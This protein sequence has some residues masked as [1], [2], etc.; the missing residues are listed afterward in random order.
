MLVALLALV[1][2]STGSAV[3][4]SLITSKQIKDGTIQTKDISKKAQKALRGKTGPQGPQGMHGPKGDT[5]ATGAQGPKG[6]TGDP[7][8]NGTNGTNGTDGAPGTAR[9]YAQVGATGSVVAT[10]SKNIQSVSHPGTGVYCVT[11]DPAVVPDVTK[12]VLVATVDYS[13]ASGL[14]MAQWRSSGIGC[15]AGEMTVRIWT[16]N[17]GAETASDAGFSVAIR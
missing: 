6:D 13:S 17:A 14:Q 5:G 9:A 12:A 11:P 3:A 15:S 2:A 4:A 16:T 8:T 10:R 1:M 7:G